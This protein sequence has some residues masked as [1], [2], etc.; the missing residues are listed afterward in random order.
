VN[1]EEIG[2]AVRLEEANKLGNE[3]RVYPASMELID[4]EVY[5]LTS[6][7]VAVVGIAD[8]INDARE[9][10]LKGINAVEGGALWNRSDIASGE[11]I[12]KSIEHMERLRRKSR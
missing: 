2:K 7:A 1:R 3:V 5:A 9:L 8:T 11:H 10:S 4:S 12:Q 6:R